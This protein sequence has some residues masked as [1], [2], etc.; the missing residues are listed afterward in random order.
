MISTIHYSTHV[1][2]Y[3]IHV[4]DKRNSLFRD[5]SFISE[6]PSKRLF[7]CE[8]MPTTISR[9]AKIDRFYHS[10]EVK[11][12]QR[13]R[14]QMNNTEKGTM[15]TCFTFHGQAL[16]GTAADIECWSF[17]CSQRGVN[18]RCT[19]YTCGLSCVSFWWSKYSLNVLNIKEKECHYSCDIYLC[20]FLLTIW[21]CRG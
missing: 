15:K 3:W 21:G 14:V 6:V 9:R 20:S 16:R 13:D 2:K 4:C 17:I 7:I 19:Q 10:E 8:M 12:D 18:A 1:R 5:I 11:G